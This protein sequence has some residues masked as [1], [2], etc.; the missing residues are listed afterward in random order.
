MRD[1]K[2]RVLISFIA[3]WGAMHIPTMLKGLLRGEPKSMVEMRYYLAPVA[4]A[5]LPIAVVGICRVQRWGF[6]LMGVAMLL[7]FASYPPLA[8]FPCLIFLFVLLRFW[9]SRYAPGTSPADDMA[10]S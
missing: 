8:F 9:L 7:A 2:Y 4:L 10:R 3:I 1:R 6:V 5:L